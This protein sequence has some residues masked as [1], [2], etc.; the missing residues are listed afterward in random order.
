ME[1]DDAESAFLD[2]YINCIGQLCF[3]LILFS[4]MPTPSSPLVL[5][6]ILIGYVFLTVLSLVM[7]YALVKTNTEHLHFRKKYKERLDLYA[8]KLEGDR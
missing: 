8:A 3:V 5:P 7:L 4:A 6:A 2:R 1:R